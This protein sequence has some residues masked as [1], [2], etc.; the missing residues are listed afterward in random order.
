M[1]KL[2]NSTAVTVGPQGRVVIPSEIRR[3][4]GIS[5]G[6]VLLALVEDQRLVLEKR[7]AVLQRLRRRFARVPAGV[8]LA[9]E[10][11]AERRSEAKREGTS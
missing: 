7:E 8:S 5:P 10:L 11:I 3:E 6:D 2:P 9:D 4:M 1:E